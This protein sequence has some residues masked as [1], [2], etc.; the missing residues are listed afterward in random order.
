MSKSSGEF[1]DLAALRSEGFD[2][3]HFRYLCLGAHY[4]SQLKFSW[5][6]LDGARRALQNLYNRIISLRLSLPARAQPKSPTE[7]ICEFYRRLF[8][9]ALADD[10]N[11]PVALSA[12][13]SA[14]KDTKLN[15]VSKLALVSE[16]DRILGLNLIDAQPPALPEAYITMIRER[17]RARAMGD[18]VKADEIRSR[19]AEKGVAV[20]DTVK[21]TEWYLTETE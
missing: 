7:E 9:G 3:L 17:E 12:L 6:A 11:A 15:A 13:W 4:R 5:E 1:L 21:G 19:L 16:F 2:A 8:Q 18:W 10:L 20:K 14:I